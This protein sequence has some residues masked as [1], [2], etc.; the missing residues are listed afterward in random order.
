M[1]HPEQ[2]HIQKY[3]SVEELDRRIRTL[4]TNT[5]VLKRLYFVKY[6][7]NGK[8]VEDACDLIGV[9]KPVGYIW[10]DRWNKEGY[11]GLIPRYAGGRPSKLS[12]EQKDR[13]LKLLEQKENWSTEEVRDLI[14]TEFNVEYTLKQ[15]RIILRN[16]GMMCAKPYPHDYRRPADAEEILKKDYHLWRKM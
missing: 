2:I 8:S 10:Q 3:M 15:I 13:L 6:R 1:S 14:H 9:K 11:N 5:K 7:Y 16:Y 4:E 12:K